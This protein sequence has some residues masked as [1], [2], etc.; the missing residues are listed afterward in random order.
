MNSNAHPIQNYIFIYIVLIFFPFPF[1]INFFFNS[2]IFLKDLLFFLVACSLIFNFKKVYERDARAQIKRIAFTSF[3]ILLIVH[4]FSLINYMTSDYS[5]KNLTLFTNNFLRSVMLSISFVTFF[6]FFA[7]RLNVELISSI[8]KIYSYICL[9]IFFEFCFSII[10]NN[11]SNFDLIFR[12]Y[13]EGIFRSLFIN[14]HIATTVH[15]CIGFFISLNLFEIYKKKIF[16][17]ISILLLI[18]IF[19]NL[20]TRLTILAFI[21]TLFFYFF[22][23]NKSSGFRTIIF[24][25]ILYFVL[26]L[27]FLNFI[28]K[29]GYN[30]YINLNGFKI[31]ADSLLDR[32]NSSIAFFT[33]FLNFPLGMGLENAGAFLELNQFTPLIYFGDVEHF[34]ALITY[35]SHYTLPHE[36]F[37]KPHGYLI[38]FLTSFG[39]FIFPIILIFKHLYNYNAN[40]NHY[41]FCTSIMIIFFSSA[42][43]INY[44]YEIE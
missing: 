18:P 42:S 41:T 9:L 40:S 16:A 7:K 8:F 29:D 23:K 28:Y 43:I 13:P 24:A 19:Y 1:K 44:I 35:F 27:F 26:I 12:I 4:L 34:S 36:V 39:I 37:A 3:S 20:E 38:N 25:N 31:P 2:E 5:H 11:F 15:L 14:G 6:L 21:Y 17:L 10:F 30:Y 22:N 32:I 33:T